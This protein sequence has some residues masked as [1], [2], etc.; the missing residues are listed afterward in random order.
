M[1]QITKLLRNEAADR[2]QNRASEPTKLVLENVA[3]IYGL[4]LKTEP[5]HT[6]DLF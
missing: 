6:A 1:S 4:F 5:Q 3:F 2:G